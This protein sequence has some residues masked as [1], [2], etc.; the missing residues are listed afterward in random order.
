[1]C[2]AR[3][4]CPIMVF[5]KF[6]FT[7]LSHFIQINITMQEVANALESYFFVKFLDH[8]SNAQ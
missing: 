5:T 3:F 8:L 2:G 7:K 4:S 1:M 6:Y